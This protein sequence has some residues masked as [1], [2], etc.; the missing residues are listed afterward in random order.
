MLRAEIEAAK[1]KA[2][3]EESTFFKIA[4]VAMTITKVNTWM[5]DGSGFFSILESHNPKVSIYLALRLYLCSE[6]QRR[7][8]RILIHLK[9]VNCHVK[10]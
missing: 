1:K 6:I 5:T 3:A 4:N 10:L 7:V 9:Q 8:L 2:L